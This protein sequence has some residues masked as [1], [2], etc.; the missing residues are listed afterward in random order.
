MPLTSQ[1]FSGDT[2]L[3]SAANNQPPL[4]MGERGQAIV[5]FQTGLLFAGMP[6]PVSTGEMSK[7]PDGIFGRETDGAVRSFQRSHSLGA[8]GIPGRNTMTH[9]DEVVRAMATAP[10]PRCGNCIV[11]NR[12]RAGA[13]EQ[14]LKRMIEEQIAQLPSVPRA[15]F[16]APVASVLGTGIQLPSG[17]RLLNASQETTARSVYSSS[18]DFSRILIS[19]ALGI[20]GRG[21][22]VALRV[23]IL[24]FFVVMNMGTFSPGR[25]LLIHEL[26]HAWQS[27]HHITK[28]AFM[29][30]SAASQGLAEAVKK[31]TGAAASAYA[32]I[33]GKSFGLYAAEQIAQQVEKGEG[34]IVSHVAARLPH[35]PD[36]FNI[37]SLTVPRYEIVGAPG[38]KT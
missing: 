26:A 22:T 21:F 13:L 33:P 34:A 4:R 28:T 32:H 18:L 31:V 30:N 23:P 2:R 36:P 27:Q 29:V 14:T 9:L 8:D 35:V 25:D 11:A 17:A 19:D 5:L 6:L 7:A 24:G 10:E 16:S 12:G 15:N 37:A 1:L 38:V 3:Q 20:G